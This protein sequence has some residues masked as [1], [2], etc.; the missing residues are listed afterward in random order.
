MFTLDA[1]RCQQEESTSLF[2]LGRKIYNFC[3][4]RKNIERNQRLEFGREGCRGPRIKVELKI[5]LADNNIKQSP[6]QAIHSP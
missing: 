6:T 3:I 2:S 4:T 1:N 5:V